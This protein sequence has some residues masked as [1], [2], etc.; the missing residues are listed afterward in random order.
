ME[1]PEESRT[2][3]VCGVPDLLS[4]SR[5]ADKLFIHFQSVRSRG[6]D[7]QAIQYPTSF[8]GV[9]FVTFDSKQDA[10]RVLMHDQVMED[11]EFP[12]RYPLTV[13]RF[14]LDVFFFV[15]AEV[16][17]SVFSDRHQ[18]VQTLKARHRSVRVSLQ[19]SSLAVMVEGP[20]LAIKELREDLNQQVQAGRDQA[21]GK[22]PK[23]RVTLEAMAS[24]GALGGSQECSTWVDT[25]VFRYIQRFHIRDLDHCLLGHNMGIKS[26]EHDDLTLITVSGTVLASV[27][28]A[29]SDLELLVATRQSVLCAQKIDYGRGDERHIEALLRYCTEINKLYDDVLVLHRESGVEVVGPASS[30][31]TFCRLVESKQLSS[32]GFLLEGSSHTRSISHV[33]PRDTSSYHSLPQ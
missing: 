3:V 27:R 20:F 22:S 25:T 29:L 12:G 24:E 7:V 32:A 13:F 33:G 14:S 9:A 6:G 15:R 30:V 5:M 23:S 8:K 2:L 28:A 4:T 11:R 26:E 16:D 19:P 17:M 1:P 10:E 21:R 18:L 31:K